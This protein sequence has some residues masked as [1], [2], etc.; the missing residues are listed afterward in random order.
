MT[1][2]TIPI[3]GV[4]TAPKQSNTPFKGQENRRGRF[5]LKLRDVMK[6]SESGKVLWEGNIP[7]AQMS[8][9][10]FP[11]LFALFNIF[12]WSHYLNQVFT[13][14]IIYSLPPTH[15][16]QTERQRQ[17]S[18]NSPLRIHTSH[19]LVMCAN[20]LVWLSMQWLLVLCLISANV[21]FAIS[22]VF[23]AKPFCPM[24][25]HFYCSIPGTERVWSAQ[26]NRT[27]VTA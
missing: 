13:I 24:Y 27:E 19:L 23:K 26:P 10:L 2:K 3:P 21:L 22:L 15:T 5:S 16:F 8:R 7:F 9:Y 17:F 25:N 20:S 18:K 12:Y 11:L 14:S 4:R 1:Q 6:N